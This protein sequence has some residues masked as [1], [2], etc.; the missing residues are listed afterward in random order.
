MQRRCSE[1]WCSF[2]FLVLSRPFKLFSYFFC[3]SLDT[4]LEKQGAVQRVLFVIGGYHK[5][6]MQSE[7]CSLPLNRFHGKL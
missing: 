7:L 1:L 6:E 4:S 5:D 2:G 3:H